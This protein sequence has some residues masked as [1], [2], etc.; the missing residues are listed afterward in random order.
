MILRKPCSL[1]LFC[2]GGERMGIELDIQ[3]F[4][5]VLAGPRRK[6]HKL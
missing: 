1:E 6:T 2:G 3:L 5:V 4:R